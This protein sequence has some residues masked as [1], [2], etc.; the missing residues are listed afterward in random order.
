MLEQKDIADDISE[1]IEETD[2]EVKTLRTALFSK[3]LA[4]HPQAAGVPPDALAAFELTCFAGKPTSLTAPEKSRVVD[5]IFK[6][7]KEGK[8]KAYFILINDHSWGYS[9]DVE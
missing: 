2:R 6:S 9:D 1:L 4:D 5:R 7:V 3:F 8:K